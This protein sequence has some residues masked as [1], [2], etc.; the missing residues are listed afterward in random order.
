MSKN[1]IKI[2][3][4]FQNTWLIDVKKELFYEENQILFGDTLRLSIS[5]N[6]SYYFA[7][8]IG[9]THE[10]DIL[11]KETPTEEEITFFNNMRSERE[12][13]FSLALAKKHNIHHYIIPND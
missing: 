10:K 8:N 2:V 7:E 12:K 6:D 13:I 3:T 11:S 9:L 1:L 5:K 4:S